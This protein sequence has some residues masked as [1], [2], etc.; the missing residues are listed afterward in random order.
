MIG[1]IG[2]DLGWLRQL[3]LVMPMKETGAE[4]G[5]GAAMVERHCPEAPHMVAARQLFF[6]HEP[7]GTGEGFREGNASNGETLN[8]PFSEELQHVAAPGKPSSVF[9]LFAGGEE[10]GLP[11]S[12]VGFDRAT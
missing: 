2:H 7:E 4:S 6:V 10:F 11:F 1:R 9:R 3:H 8:K 5:N 12:E